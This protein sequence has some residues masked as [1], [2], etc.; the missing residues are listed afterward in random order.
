MQSLQE[1]A[2]GAAHDYRAGSPHLK[3]WRLYDRLVSL[4]RAEIQAIGSQGLPLTVLEVGAGHGGLT[5]P[6]LAMGCSVTATE[7][8]QHALAVLRARYSLNPK[9]SA[10]FDGD[11]T[12]D[13][14]GD[15]KVSLIVCA[16]VLHHIP[17]YR[18]FLKSGIAKHLSRGGALLTIQDPLWYPDLR[19]PDEWLTKAGYFSWRVAQGNYMQGFRTRMRRIRGH[20]DEENPRDMVEYHVVRSGL[21]HTDIV[22][23]LTPQFATIRLVPYW[24][25]QS[26]LFQRLGEWLRRTNTFALVARGFGGSVIGPPPADAPTAADGPA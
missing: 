19:Q 12:L 3:H 17:D 11:G 5:E 8:S 4:L 26:T 13:A 18:E 15:E 23:D 22:A 7:M 10:V 6:A 24:S 21:N 9:F 20:Y 16:S 14:F 1:A 2:H 25:T